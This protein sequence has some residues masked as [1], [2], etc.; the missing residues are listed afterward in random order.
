M[1]FPPRQISNF[2]FV[3]VVSSPKSFFWIV[4]LCVYTR[5]LIQL[6][7]G[8]MSGLQGLNFP[9]TLKLSYIA[10]VP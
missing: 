4:F 8:G 6:Y 2:D 3:I 7:Y 5:G 9:L 1:N 10:A